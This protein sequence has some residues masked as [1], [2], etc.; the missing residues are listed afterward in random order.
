MQVI[1]P[2]FPNNF[3][4]SIA[5]MYNLLIPNRGGGG[6]RTG[7]S[8]RPPSPIA[9]GTLVVQYQAFARFAYVRACVLND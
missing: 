9:D 3:P 6:D 2:V 7:I 4:K 5:V 8:T 1:D